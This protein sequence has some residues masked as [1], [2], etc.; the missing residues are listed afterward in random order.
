MVTVAVKAVF[1]VRLAAGGVKV[2]IRP[3]ESRAT[4][5][6]TFAP[7]VV[8]V[9][10]A[11]LIVAGFI[12]L[13]NVALIIATLGHTR[14]DPFRGVT[15]VTV[16]GVRAEPG[17]PLIASGSLHPEITTASRNAGIKILLIFKLRISFSSSHASKAIHIEPRAEI[18]G[19]ADSW[20]VQV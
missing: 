17:P 2:A 18:Y 16:G 1:G 20:S 11:V 12:V 7:P 4:V 3:V 6:V 15:E 9:K 14:V 13:V 8:K 19:I 10:V 5:P